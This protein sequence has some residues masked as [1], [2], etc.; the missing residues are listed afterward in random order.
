MTKLDLLHSNSR[1]FHKTNQMIV[2]KQLVD[3]R[4]IIFNIH[5]DNVFAM[6]IITFSST[7]SSFKCNNRQHPKVLFCYRTSFEIKRMII[8]LDLILLAVQQLREIRDYIT[9]DNYDL[10]Q[11]LTAFKILNL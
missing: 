2:S 10:F 1:Y 5:S 8:R 7:P 6:N 4:I 3:Q 9:D 11:T